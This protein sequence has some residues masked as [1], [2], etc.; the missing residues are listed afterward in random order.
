MTLFNSPFTGQ[1]GPPTV[2][3]NNA[4]TLNGVNQYG[5]ISNSP[6]T[7]IGGATTFDFWVQW[8][9]FSQVWSRVFDFS[10]GQASNN[11]LIAHEASSSN[12]VF[13]VYSGSTPVISIKLSG[14]WSMG[15]W[16]R[17]TITV[18]V[19]GN[20]NVYRDGVL[21]DLSNPPAG[22]IVLSNVQG[23]PILAVTRT[24]NYLGRSAWG[25][26]GFANSSIA[27]VRVLTGVHPP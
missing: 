18:D 5:T 9:S 13:E 20:V 17:V 23:T 2:G 3:L 10:N 12:F 1:P 8:N 15:V 7:I 4:I 6:T 27:D 19:S 22:I 25:G 24:I 14:F 16:V 21:I 26:D 11:I